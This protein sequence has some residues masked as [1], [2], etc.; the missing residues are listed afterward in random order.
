LTWLQPASDVGANPMDFPDLGVPKSVKVAC[1][2]TK[3]KIR[4]FNNVGTSD[5]GYGEGMAFSNPRDMNNYF[6]G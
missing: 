2:V 3:I 1:E 5:P 6:F 4:A